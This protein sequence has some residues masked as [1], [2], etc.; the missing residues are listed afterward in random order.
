M[1]FKKNILTMVVAGFA[2][3]MPA[4]A[5][6]SNLTIIKNALRI[7]RKV[8]NQEIDITALPLDDKAT[9]ELLARGDTTGGF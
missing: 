1:L 3:T 6:G 7:I 5:L 4:F 2:F 8:H 9:F